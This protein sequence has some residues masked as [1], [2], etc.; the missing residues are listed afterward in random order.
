MPKWIPCGDGF[1]EADVIRWKE[2]VWQRPKRKRGDAVHL[3]DRIVTAEV[4]RDEDGWVDLLIRGYAVSHEIPGRKVEVLAKG[5]EIH[6]QRST[7]ERGKPER[8]KWSD[9]TARSLLASE[10][11]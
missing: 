3:G 7:I 11:L 8:L 6:R 1:I 5:T 4:I 9:E 2:D 10:Y